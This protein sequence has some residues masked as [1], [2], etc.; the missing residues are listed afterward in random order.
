MFFVAGKEPNTPAQTKQP[1]HG[2]SKTTHK[3]IGLQ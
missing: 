2:R 3:G 1:N